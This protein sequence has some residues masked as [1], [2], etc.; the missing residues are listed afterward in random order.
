VENLVKQIGSEFWN[1]SHLKL[2]GLDYQAGDIDS[3]ARAIEEIVSD[4]SRL[5]AMKQNSRH[6]AE[7][8]YDCRVLCQHYVQLV[9]KVADTSPCD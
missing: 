8:T 1:I 6:L 7:T 3:C 9:E 5:Q 4:P 2:S